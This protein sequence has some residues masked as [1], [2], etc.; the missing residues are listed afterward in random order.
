MPR[1]PK[2]YED[3]IQNIRPL[4]SYDDHQSLIYEDPNRIKVYFNGVFSLKRIEFLHNNVAFTINLV[5][6]SFGIHSQGHIQQGDF[7]VFKVKKNPSNRN[8]AI[9][10]RPFIIKMELIKD[11]IIVV[12]WTPWTRGNKL[13]ENDMLFSKNLKASL[14]LNKLYHWIFGKENVV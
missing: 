13:E 5:D 2:D 4:K 6:F 3:F 11:G 9:Y 10:V 8:F 12:N 1:K 7:S 14:N